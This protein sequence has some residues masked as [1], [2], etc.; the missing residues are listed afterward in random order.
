MY[1]FITIKI[2]KYLCITDTCLDLNSPY[3]RELSKYDVLIACFHTAK[4][5]RPPTKQPPTDYHVL[6]TCVKLKRNK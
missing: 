2:I 3:K 5:E 6:K 1:V 4:F